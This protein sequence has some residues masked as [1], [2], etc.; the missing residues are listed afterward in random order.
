[1]AATQN[2]LPQIVLVPKYEATQDCLDLVGFTR[3]IKSKN[4]ILNPCSTRVQPLNSVPNVAKPV[5]GVLT[6]FHFMSEPIQNGENASSGIP[7]LICCVC[8]CVTICFIAFRFSP[9][10]E[11]QRRLWS[12]IM[13]QTNGT[14]TILGDTRQLEF[15]T[16]SARTKDFLHLDDGDVIATEKWEVIS[17]DDVDLEFGKILHANKGVLGYRRVEV[18][19]E[20]RTSFKPGWWWTVNVFT[21]YSAG[22]LGQTYQNFWK[23]SAP[24]FVE[25]IDNR[26]RTE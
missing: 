4:H 24:V 23:P 10:P 11:P 13:V 18:W 17:N 25:L 7:G 6:H 2:H 14:E 15:W 21:N 8:I 26:G 20:G 1:M 12:P 5:L 19:G 16:P 9:A 22:E 3:H